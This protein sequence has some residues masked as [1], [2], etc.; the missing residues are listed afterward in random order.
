MSATCD[1][2]DTWFD[3]DGDPECTQ[4]GVNNNGIHGLHE[5]KMVN[6]L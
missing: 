6:R 5:P 1:E 3:E 4:T 2:V